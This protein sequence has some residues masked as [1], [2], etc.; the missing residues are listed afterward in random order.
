MI[1][2]NQHAVPRIWGE[3]QQQDNTNKIDGKAI[4]EKGRMEIKI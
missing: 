2:Y 3:E 4:Q 1:G